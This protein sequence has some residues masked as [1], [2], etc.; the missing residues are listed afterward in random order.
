MYEAHSPSHAGA[1]YSDAKE[2]LYSA[3]TIAQQLTLWHSQER[4]A[5]VQAG[6]RQVESG[7]RRPDR[8]V[9]ITEKPSSLPIA[10]ADRGI[11]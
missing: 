4:V 6:S 2:A 5:E 10:E 8:S 9:T 7:P 11:S 3:I 1:C